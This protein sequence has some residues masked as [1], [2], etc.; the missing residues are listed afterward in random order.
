MRRL[1]VGSVWLLI[2][3]SLCFAQAGYEHK[4]NRLSAINS[5]LTNLKLPAVVLD[6]ANSF[7]KVLA[8]RRSVR[9]FTTD[10]LNLAEVG[11]LAWAGQGITHKTS[12]FRTAPSA[13]AIYPIQ[14]YFAV[15]GGVYLYKPQNHSLQ[16]VLTGNILDKLA[17]AAL[18]QQPVAKAACD[19]IVVGSPQKTMA[20]YGKRGRK[21]ML[22]EAGHIA[23]NIQLQA[24][25]LGLG[26]VT[27]GAFDDAQVKNLCRFSAAQEPVYIICVGYPLAGPAIKPTETTKIVPLPESTRTQKVVFI[28]PGKSFQNEELFIT[29]DVLSAATVESIVA[30][31]RLGIIKDTRRIGQVEATLHINDIVVD[32]YDGI[33]FVGGLGVGKYVEDT[34]VLDIAREAARKGKV[35]AAI[36]TTPDILAQAGILDGRR[37]T[38]NRTKRREL[39]KAG[40]EYTGAYVE[41]DEMIITARDARSSSEFGK[42]ITN[43]LAD[44]PEPQEEEKTRR[45]GKRKLREHR[46]P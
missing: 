15:R 8:S 10:E 2:L 45:Y 34:V 17:V 46:T 40:A 22:M 36:G 31:S 28:I 42:V 41:R 37:A 12:G 32:D 13:G 6:G 1:F 44:R 23:Q 20:K 35:V 11:Q 33:I 39:Q 25:S 43:A 27:I 29:R 19:I 24:V 16:K 9:Q 26:S 21:Y 18:N 3:A 4:S 7:E 5:A 38:S 30:C 14:L